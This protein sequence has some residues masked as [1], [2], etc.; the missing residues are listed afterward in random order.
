VKIFL[1][2]IGIQIS[3]PQLRGGQSVRVSSGSGRMRN[4]RVDLV[5]RNSRGVELKGMA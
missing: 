5:D 3:S 2:G 1:I 4:R